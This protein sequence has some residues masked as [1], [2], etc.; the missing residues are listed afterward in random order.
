MAQSTCRDLP[1]ASNQFE[2]RHNSRVCGNCCDCR[3][4]RGN[5]HGDPRSSV[6][7][8]GGRR[9]AFGCCS[10]TLGRRRRPRRGVS[11]RP[12]DRQAL[13]LPC[14]IRSGCLPVETLDPLI[15]GS[16]I[17]SDH[18][19]FSKHES[20][21]VTGC[22]RRHGPRCASLRR[23]RRII[24]HF[25]ILIGCV[26]TPMMDGAGRPGNRLPAAAAGRA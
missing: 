16:L 6:G 20:L 1:S 2:H 19:A 8:L 13:F 3:G 11:R 23:R 18:A 17:S 4:Y 15:G 7:A 25:R 24:A 12:G 26:A 10:I 21:K 9:C 5:S 22:I 14:T